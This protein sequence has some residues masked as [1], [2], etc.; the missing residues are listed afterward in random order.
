MDDV[1]TAARTSRGS[2]EASGGGADPTGG[3]VVEA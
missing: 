3:G 2:K 1:A